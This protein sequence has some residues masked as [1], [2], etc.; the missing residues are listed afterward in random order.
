MHFLTEMILFSFQRNWIRNQGWE[1]VDDCEE[2]S[3]LLNFI[4]NDLNHCRWPNG[5]NSQFKHS[6][7]LLTAKIDSYLGSEGKQTVILLAT[8]S[9]SNSA[10]TSTDSYLG[11][12]Q[13]LAAVS[14]CDDGAILNDD[15]IAELMSRL[16]QRC[17]NDVEMVVVANNK[18]E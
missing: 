2:G 11:S 10:S 15:Y 13:K 1:R 17:V 8:K 7:A 16:S 6:V 5:S 9:S 4:Q 14:T 18:D 3:F 12:Q